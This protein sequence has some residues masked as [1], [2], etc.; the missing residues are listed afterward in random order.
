MHDWTYVPLS[1][2]DDIRTGMLSTQV[3]METTMRLAIFIGYYSKVCFAFDTTYCKFSLSA[4]QA[5]T[6]NLS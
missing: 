1:T 6:S 3:S 5:W 2:L 4:N